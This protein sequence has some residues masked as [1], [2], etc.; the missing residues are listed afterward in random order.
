[1]HGIIWAVVLEGD[2]FLNEHSQDTL[3]DTFVV[4]TKPIKKVE[5][6]EH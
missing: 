5:Y 1:V 3:L 4:T 6:V 2:A